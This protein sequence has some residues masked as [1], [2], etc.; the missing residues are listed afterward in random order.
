MVY[1]T[2]IHKTITLTYGTYPKSCKSE[3]A[4]LSVP[5]VGLKKLISRLTLP[6]RTYCNAYNEVVTE[7]ELSNRVCNNYN[8]AMRLK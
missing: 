5:K 1:S 6:S 4:G 3:I 7:S 2:Y 8:S